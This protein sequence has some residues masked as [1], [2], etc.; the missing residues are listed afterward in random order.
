LSGRPLR[1]L[2]RL[3]HR[4]LLM[5][6][7][8]A[9]PPAALAG[10]MRFC[11]RPLSLSAP[12]KDELFRFGAIV[13]DALEQS[14]Q[15]V[16]IVARSGLKLGRFGVR[17]SHAGVSLKASANT[18]W[19][20]RQLYYACDEGQPRLFDQGMSGF[21]L[22]T[23][24]PDKGYVSIVTLPPEPAAALEAAALSNAR[25]LQVLHP[26]YSANAYA[27]GLHYQNC[28]QWLAELLALAWG[29][30]GAAV[31]AADAA[32]AEAAPRAQ[33][34]QWLRTHGYEPTA[35]DV[36][37]PWMWLGMLSPFLHVGDHPQA[38]V[39]AGIYRVSMPAAIATFVQRTQPG[40]QRVELC[41]KHGRVV[42]H[43]GWD[44]MTE[45]CEPGP[46]DTV[47]TLDQGPGH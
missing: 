26:A 39:E 13:K 2:A 43:R 35:L 19:S 5:G 44:L 46:G 45:G 20:V 11:D 3:A 7:V 15:R 23:D 42:V 37:G 36:G 30:V 18:P 6:L 10:S 33:A 8:L 16:A 24:D 21:V 4:G 25:S 31:D 12:Q 40:A 38:D 41:H 29:G 27:F 47:L 14:G 17:Y 32:A 28:N 1:A 9:A 34:Q 22:G